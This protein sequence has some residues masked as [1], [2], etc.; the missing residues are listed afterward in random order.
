LPQ[1]A[2]V[3]SNFYYFFPPVKS[4]DKTFFENQSSKPPYEQINFILRKEDF[5][6]R[7][8]YF[9]QIMN[10]PASPFLP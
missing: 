10:F 8:L 9:E 1:F 3:F 6:A 5:P 7:N 4:F 2:P